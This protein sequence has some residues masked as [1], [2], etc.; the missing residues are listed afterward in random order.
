M[1]KSLV[2]MVAAAFCLGVVSGCVS[3]TAVETKVPDQTAKSSDPLTRAQ[4]HTER[5]AEYFR[6]GNMAV[7]LEATKQALAASPNHAPAHNMLGIIYMQLK[8]D[9][10]AAQ[11]FEQALRLVPN[12]SE[13][14]NNYGWFICQ[15]QNPANATQYFQ[16][17]LKNPL[18]GTPER[19][20][21][22]SGICLKKAGDIVGAEAQFR[23]AVRRQP[24]M[25]AALYELAEI[26]FTRGR[27]REAE[28]FLARHNQLVQ[29]PNADV[30]LLGA[31]IAYM[32]GDKSALSSY[33]Q[34]LR[35]RFPD[36][37]QTRAAAELR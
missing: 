32:Q 24:L 22:N 30:L 5:A 16:A 33:V 14:L 17:A 3:T 20:N 31:R 25:S 21:Y 4:I 9:A 6:I 35:R 37:A 1:N 27:S 26:E 23:E 12:D 7:A 29:M 28:G 15:R 10:Q 13:T 36:A 11:A 19:A 34:Q 2:A 8:D 18:Y